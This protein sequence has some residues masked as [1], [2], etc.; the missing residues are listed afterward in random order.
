MFKSRFQPKA[1]AL[2]ATGT[3]L[4]LGGFLSLNLAGC[5]GGNG[6]GLGV[7]KVTTTPAP[8]PIGV[9]FQ[10]QLPSVQAG[11][12]TTGAGSSASGGTVTLTSASGRTY[13]GTANKTG[14]VTIRGVV[15][16]TYNVVFTTIDQNGTRVT[17]TRSITIMAAKGT[18]SQVQFFTLIQGNTG[19]TTNPNDPN[20]IAENPYVVSGIVYLNQN[21]PGGGTNPLAQCGDFNPVTDAIYIQVKDLNSTNGQPIIAQILRQPQ[22][23]NSTSSDK[24]KFSIRIP[25]RPRSFQVIILGVNA[26][27]NFN[28]TTPTADPNAP[29]APF[30]GVSAQATFTSSDTEVGGLIICANQDVTAPVFGP[31]PT[32]TDTPD[33]GGTPIGIPGGTPVGTPGSTPVGTPGSTPVGT[34]GGT[35][36]GTPR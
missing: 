9:S 5:G 7:P 1:S 26:P 15:P 17:T 36:V 35:P 33:P 31:T 20:Y 24:G 4:V 25:Y 19:S 13:T 30:A 34:P 21:A 18:G 2:C 12:G 14:R 22:D 6:G 8:T 16:G 3:L 28:G 23:P 27:T 11:D 10:L 32:P 29:T